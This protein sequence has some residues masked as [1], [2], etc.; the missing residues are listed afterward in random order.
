VIDHWGGPKPLAA[1]VRAIEPSA[2]TRVSALGVE[3]QRVNVVL[4]LDT[5]R[6]EWT[7]L[8]DGYRVE[9]RIVAWSGDAVLSAPAS[10][11]FRERDHWATFEMQADRARLVPVVLGQRNPERVEIVSGLREGAR[12]VEHPSDRLTDGARIVPR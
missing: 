8:R 6:A 1:H 3:E 12:V 9:T 11:V 10:A 7:A 4:D 2:F 5:P